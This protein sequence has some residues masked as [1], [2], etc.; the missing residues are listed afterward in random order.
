MGKAFMLKDKGG[1]ITEP[2]FEIIGIDEIKYLTMEEKWTLYDALR[3]C[4]GTFGVDVKQEMLNLYSK[5]MNQKYRIISGCRII[6]K[7]MDVFYMDEAILLKLYEAID[8]KH[9]VNIKLEERIT[10]NKILPSRIYLDEEEGIWYLEHVREG[11]PFAIDLKNIQ[12]VELLPDLKRI[13]TREAGCREGKKEI[14]RVKIRVFNE[15]NSR[16]RAMGFLLSKY[17]IDEKVSYGYSDITA[18]IINMNAFKKWV[19]EMTPQV[20]ILEPADLKL[21]FIEMASSW[22]KNYLAGI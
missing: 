2:Y 16:E 8:K 4:G 13:R 3:T 10:L 22:E 9:A 11:E 5:E 7:N 12:E 15:K 14:Q 18:N 21:Q 1:D 17:I 20:L 6:K 19:M